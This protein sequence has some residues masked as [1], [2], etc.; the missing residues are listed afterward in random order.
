MLLIGKKAPEEIVFPGFGGQPPPFPSG[1]QG[2]P[3]PSGG[4]GPPFSMGAHDNGNILPWHRYSIQVWEDALIAE[5][6]WEGGV[7]CMWKDH[8]MNVS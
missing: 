6:G 1:G 4:Q 5:C 3:F 8:K 2:P 7:P